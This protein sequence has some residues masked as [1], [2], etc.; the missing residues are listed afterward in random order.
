M[1][2]ALLAL[3]RIGVASTEPEATFL[4]LLW[5]QTR[6]R[7]PW[8]SR[9][10]AEPAIVAKYLFSLAQAFNNFYHK[11]R[12]LIERDTLRKCFLL[13]LTEIIHERLR[14]GLE[15]LGIQVPEKM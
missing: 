13:A 9:Q 6:G 2:S 12:I 10:M 4:P 8:P 7:A 5:K 1:H 14:Q 11:H 15:L 3:K